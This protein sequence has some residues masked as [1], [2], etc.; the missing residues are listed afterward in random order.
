MNDCQIPW[1]VKLLYQIY[2]STRP[3]QSLFMH[4]PCI[5]CPPFSLVTTS[6]GSFFFSWAL[7]RSCIMAPMRYTLH[8]KPSH[9]LR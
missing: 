7:T 4:Q 3:W 6:L 2:A 9:L 8:L 5:S 1:L